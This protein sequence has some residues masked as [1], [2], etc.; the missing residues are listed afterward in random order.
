MP[1]L[2][3]LGSLAVLDD[4]GRLSGAAIGGRNA[5]LLAML[6][7][8]GVAGVTRERLAA[9]L[10]P[11]SD[12]DR[13][14]HSL[15][16]AVY[17]VRRAVGDI[18]GAGASTLALEP[19]A[20]TSDVSDFTRALENGDHGLAVELYGGPF[21][22]GFHISKSAEFER[23]VDR[24]RRALEDGFL[25]TLEF[26]A[27][28]A[29]GQGEPALAIPYRRRQ[30]ATRP[31]S[32]RVAVGLMRS[33][34]A[35]GDRPGA[36]EAARAH[37]ALI[38]EALG[39]EPDPSVSAYEEELKS[40]P[41][42]V[43]G[44]A[45]AAGDAVERPAEVG[46]DGGSPAHDGGSAASDG[47]RASTRRTRPRMAI[48]LAIGAAGS[49]GAIAAAW[50]NATGPESHGD[51]PRVAVFPFEDETDD[52]ALASVGALAADWITEG[53]VRSALVRTVEPGAGA[54]V[55][56]D[57]RVYVVRDTL[58]LHA[59]VASAATGEVIGVADGA[60]PLSDGPAGAVE[61]VRRRVLGALGSRYDPRL[62]TW[63]ET[64]SR[65]PDYDAYREFASGLELFAMPRDPR[66]AAIRFG[67]AA[68]IDPGFVAPRLWGAWALT[69]TDYG[70]ADSA[71]RVAEP[72]RDVMSPLQRAWYDRMRSWL[73]GDG[74]ASLRAARRMAEI[75]PTSGWVLALANAAS[76]A[77]RPREAIAALEEVGVES[78][79]AEAGYGFFLLGA[80]YH[81]LGDYEAELRVAER[82][83]E[84]VGPGYGHLGPGVPALAA[85]G[86]LDALEQRLDALRNAPA[87][88]GDAPAGIRALYTAIVE[89][90]AHGFVEA[91]DGLAA[92]RLE[93]EIRRAD[94]ADTDRE[95]LREAIEVLYETGAWD[96]ARALI[97]EV[98]A[99]GRETWLLGLR[100]RLAAR[101]ADVTAARAAAAELAARDEPFDLGEIAF[102]RAG[103]EAALG[104]HEAALDLLREAF[105]RGRGAAARHHLHV[106]RDFDAL[107]GNPDFDRLVTPKG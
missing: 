85:L 70:R 8:A 106:A 104:N 59:R 5:A 66:A 6:A 41:P 10:W 103:I 55:T 84:L 53:L 97:R 48:G 83:M 69:F 54:E 19:D 4:G 14:R 32:A 24:E 1:R 13:A 17:V 16:Q 77:G 39:V 94:E 18:F 52:P 100:G 67:R 31:L 78:L 81:R 33:L 2:I 91:A 9:L 30:V 90:R 62:A 74:E 98:P 22:D 105:G 87:L 3:T 72:L 46:D 40:R 73:D 88:E 36:I 75:A 65:P 47:S 63:A 25:E 57:G 27:Q 80:A 21:L 28:Q 29:D 56:I 61:A 12:S 45:T 58:R 64:V 95:A 89:L 42:L 38:R 26:L 34:E 107:R 7:R 101:S 23:W 35:A 86:R 71:L 76:D 11:E 92:R 37:A 102:E 44:S 68:T 99:G 15:D 82:G 50:P 43:T 93:Q 49:V 51:V 20:I 60:S 79:G 96:E